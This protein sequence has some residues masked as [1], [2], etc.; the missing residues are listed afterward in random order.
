MGEEGE[1]RAAGEGGLTWVV[2]PLDG[3]TNFANGL[4]SFCCSIA[5]VEHGE[6]VVGA[7]F[8][9]WPDTPGGR[10]F[11]ARRG[12]GAW[13]GEVRLQVAPGEKPVAGRVTVRGGFI[14][15][16]FRPSKELLKNA[17]QQR[18]VGSTAYELALTADGTYQFTLHGAPHSW[19]V[20]A[21]DRAGAGG[22]RDGLEPWSRGLGTADLVP[23]RLGQRRRDQAAPGLA[24]DG[25][26]RQRRHGAVCAGGA[27]ATA[28]EHSRG[29]GRQAGAAEP[30]AQRLDLLGDPEDRWPSLRCS[31]GR[32]SGWWSSSA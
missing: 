6:P 18:S 29:A 4:P 5:L 17:G 10:V 30:Q 8:L 23:E 3:T 7:I 9:P 15:G 28:P 13:E 12:G 22:R 31:P 24:A 32:S 1:G 14:P 11:H 25:A 20:A 26:V 16:R 27:A 2:D 19:D 21:G